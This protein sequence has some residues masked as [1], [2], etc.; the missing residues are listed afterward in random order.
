MECGQMSSLKRKKIST[1]PM[2]IF[3]GKKKQ[4][5]NSAFKITI[6]EDA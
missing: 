2:E 5:E 3:L 1:G 6:L 4:R